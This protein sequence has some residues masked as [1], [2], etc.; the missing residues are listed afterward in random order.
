VQ[1]REGHQAQLWRRE[2]LGGGR[3]R[4]PS[5]GC[6]AAVDDAGH[7]KVAV[8]EL[9]IGLQQLQ[10]HYS[11]RG[12][13]HA[14]DHGL[15]SGSTSVS[16]NVSIDM[17]RGTHDIVGFEIGK[18]DLALGSQGESW[19]TGVLQKALNIRMVVER[20]AKHTLDETLREMN[21]EGACGFVRGALADLD[22]TTLDFT[23]GDAVKAHVPLV[24]D[25]DI[26]VNSTDIEP[27]TSMKCEH[28]GFNG[29]LITARIDDVPF[30]MGFRWAYQKPNS[31]F[32][33][34]EGN[35][36]AKVVAG[37]LLHVNLL[38]PS[39]TH[40]EVKLP[41]LDLQLQAESD[42]WMYS[43][44]SDVMAPL[45]R[46]SLQTFGGQVLSSRVE[47]CLADPGCPHIGPE[48]ASGL[49]AGRAAQEEESEG[50]TESVL[51]V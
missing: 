11:Q 48:Q 33:H 4:T 40:I 10:W 19:L 5:V 3:L 34:N 41:T 8:S 16:F 29:S 51:I 31:S 46:E 44:L 37:T 26:S 38:R 24:G 25:V 42:A 36:S 2:I 12:F 22:L 39:E 18:V 50:S 17:A 32:W 49:R 47:Q 14:A 21:D 20:A 43:A 1:P 9:D 45:V 7:F 23:T 6:D 27:P 13:P 30:A 28:L 35:G 15:A